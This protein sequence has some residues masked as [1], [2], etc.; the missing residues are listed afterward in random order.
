MNIVRR[1]GILPQ[2]TQ[3]AQGYKP[4]EALSGFL[5][6]IQQINDQ[7]KAASQGQFSDAN[8]LVQ[9]YIKLSAE[10]EKNAGA[11]ENTAAAA[12]DT[13]IELNT[14][15][16]TYNDQA[17]AAIADAKF[18]QDLSKA[19]S[20]QLQDRLEANRSEADAIQQNAA[21]LTG[22]Q[23]DAA[24]A[25]EDQLDHEK[26]LI[27]DLLPAAFLKN[28]QDFGKAFA[29]LFSSNALQNSRTEEDRLIEARNRADDANK[30]QTRQLQDQSIARLQQVQDFNKQQSRA[31]EDYLTSRAKAQKQYDEQAQQAE[32]DQQTKLLRIISEAR[33]DILKAAAELDARAVYQDQQ[34]RDLQLAEAADDFRTQRSRQQ[35]QYEEQQADQQAQFELQRSRAQADF[36]E[37]I[38][39]QDA[40]RELQF[41]RQHED[42]DLQ[43]QR[44]NAQYAL[45]NARREQDFQNQ[46]VKLIQ[47]NQ[48]IQSLFG[49]GLKGL[50]DQIATFWAKVNAGASPIGQGAFQL[51][52]AV[53]NIFNTQHLG[54][55][56]L[57]AY[58][59]TKGGSGTP[60]PT[61]DN[62]G[63]NMF[64]G[65]F[66]SNVPEAHIPLSQMAGM[67]GNFTWQG[68]L[69]LGDIGAYSPD[70]ISQ[71]V[72]TGLRNILGKGIAR[73]GGNG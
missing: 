8:A 73:L 12:G 42:Y 10:L 25:R 30:Q 39:R 26:K 56:N 17:A 23:Y 50:Q 11:V 32:E 15:N 53:G 63:V 71:L 51:G 48:V 27:E 68:D 65:I 14:L 62:G 41:R 64:P 49:L 40:Q 66:A 37:T 28:L 44:Q 57:A 21:L 13:G 67:G 9:A 7:I 29:D 22:K 31:Q 55:T 2:V 34:R 38:A 58:R 20:Q 47:H 69:V 61:F 36:Q 70:E 54:S 35:K 60:F 16:A 33:L 4:A 3:A 5:P 1:G 43:T 6:G 52:Q 59:E 45:Q 72:E 19:T 46:T 18:I 24:V